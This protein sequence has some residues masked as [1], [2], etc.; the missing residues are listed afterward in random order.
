MYGMTDLK[1]L[2]RAYTVVIGDNF[3][4]VVNEQQAECCC[5]NASNRVEVGQQITQLAAVVQIP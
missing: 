5:L 1:P 3:T 4:F 2:T